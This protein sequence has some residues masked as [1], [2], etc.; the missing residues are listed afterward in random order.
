MNKKITITIIVI[1]LLS[2]IAIFYLFIKPSY[3]LESELKEQI[4]EDLPNYKI[5]FA[6]SRGMDSVDIWITD[7]DGKNEKLLTGNKDGIDMYPEWGPNGKYIYYTSNKHGGTMEIWRVNTWG[8]PNPEQLSLFNREVRSL[9]VSADNKYITFGLM[10]S[11]ASFGADL[12][13]YSADLHILKMETL[14]KIISQKKLAKV[15]DTKVLISEPQE[16]HI[17]FEQPDF[18]KTI[19]ENE[20]PWI[21]YVRT[22]NYDNDAISTEDLWLIRADGSD[23]QLLAKGESMAKWTLNDSM[24]VTH[25]FSAID[26]KTKEIKK[27]KIDGILSSA[28]SASASPN[29]KYVLFEISDANRKAGLAKVILN[30]NKTPNPITLLSKRNAYEPRFSPVPLS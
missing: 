5:T 14:E 20:S 18:Q 15:Q 12:K 1:L 23:N 24:I 30:G 29:G 4:K 25:G 28:G 19:N 21:A 16:N 3:P 17:W 6:S 11:N 13:Q 27:L 9:S 8:N 2:I 26:I 22:S 10:T 7:V